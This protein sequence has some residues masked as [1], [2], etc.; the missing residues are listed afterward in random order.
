MLYEVA[1]C[2]NMPLQPRFIPMKTGQNSEKLL[3]LA[4]FEG[5]TQ[6]YEVLKM[7]VGMF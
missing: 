3:F 2:Q 5:V 6:G 1:E 7:A 4:V